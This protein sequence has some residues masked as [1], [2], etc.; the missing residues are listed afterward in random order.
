MNYVW[1]P[2]SSLFLLCSAPK[3]KDSNLYILLMIEPAFCYFALRSLCILNNYTLRILIHTLTHE[4][5]VSAPSAFVNIT[6]HPNPTSSP[7]MFTFVGG[8]AHAT[9]FIHAHLRPRGPANAPKLRAL[10]ETIM[11]LWDAHVVPSNGDDDTVTHSRVTEGRLDDARALH[12]VFVF[13]DLIAG[14]EQGFVLP[15]AGRDEEWMRGNMAAF[16][17]RKGDGDQ[18]IKRLMEEMHAK[19]GE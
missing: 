13:E 14:A 18:S 16:E 5:T 7:T 3:Y 6:F 8:H 12:N 2:S 17:K 19:Q 15:Q 9:N 10:V 4:H 1:L 11:K